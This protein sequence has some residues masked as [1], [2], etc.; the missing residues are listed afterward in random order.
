MTQKAVG[1]R[2]VYHARLGRRDAALADARSALA[3][4]SQALATQDQAFTIYQ[5][6]GIYALTSRQQPEDR[7]EALRLLALALRKDGS[8]LRAIP[9]DHDLD[10][11]R[12]RPEFIELI[13]AMTVIDRAT[14]Q[15]RPAQGKEKE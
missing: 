11:I 14:T 9:A 1:P 2:G 4:G 13:R 5:V 7:R 15:T 3:L 10:A 8:W 6:A 12:D